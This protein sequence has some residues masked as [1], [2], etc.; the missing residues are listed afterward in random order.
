MKKLKGEYPD[1]DAIPKVLE[2]FW[3]QYTIEQS[4]KEG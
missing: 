2:L 1:E 4:I 3:G